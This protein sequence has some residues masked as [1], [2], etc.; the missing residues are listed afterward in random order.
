MSLRAGLKWSLVTVWAL[1]M[2]TCSAG[3]GIEDDMGEENPDGGSGSLCAPGVDTDGDGLNNDVEC[4]LGTNPRK[5][6]TDGDGLWDGIE[7]KYPKV[8]VAKSSPQQRRPPVSCTDSKSCFAGETCSGVSPTKKDS[9]GDGV[10]DG[11]EDLNGDGKID[12]SRGETDPRLFDTDGDGRSD[13]ESGVG[14]CRATGLATVTVTPAPSGSVQLGFDPM[15]GKAEA[16]AG[17]SGASGLLLD[18]LGAGVA[19]AMFSINAPGADV[20]ADATTLETKLVSALGSGTTAVL[21]GRAL[22]THE[23]NP[24]VSS[25]YRVARNTT[26]SAI[27][28]TLVQPF[29]GVMPPG[30]GGAGAGTEFLLDVTTVRRG[31]RDDLIVAVAPRLA[32]ED[33]T[34]PTGIRLSDLVN[35][36]GVA[37]EGK[38]LGFNCQVFKADKPAIADFL[39]T[40]DTSGSMSDDQE[41]LGNTAI[42]FFQRMTSA[43][44]DFRVGVLTSGS[45]SLNL[46]SPGFKFINGSDPMGPLQLCQQVTVGT[47]PMGGGDA[48]QPYP[49]S[50]GSEEPIAAG[51]VAHWTFKSRP[52]PETNPDR[53][54]RD[55]ARVVVF[56]VTDEPESLTNSTTDANDWNNYFSRSQDPEL[57]KPWSSGTY[58]A[59]ALT[60]IVSYFKRNQVLTFGMVPV[61]SSRACGPN[62]HVND[63]PRCTIEGNGGA[64]IPIATALDAEVSAAMNKIVDAVAGATSQFKL[65]RSPI[66]ATIKVRVRGV[67]VPRSRSNGFDYDAAS[68]A[69]VFYGS[70]YRPMMGDEVVVS[71][72]V[73]EGSLG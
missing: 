52:M 33:Y 50:G 19:G 39:W 56:A 1:S 16:V 49:F 28:D 48:L 17:A 47:C 71:Y 58:D 67:D 62:P 44:V 24:A 35:T 11:E 18:D 36:T 45:T 65:D 70:Q 51:V 63:I 27:R 72:R 54:F 20:R 68:K 46:D 73:W 22:T 66:T 26:A 25:T 61:Y 29:V 14:I 6:D 10:N 31:G 40:V 21:T 8:C 13:S 2:A 59:T 7:V 32:L 60:N 34:K 4:M 57:K 37:Q 23:L 43:G 55:G 42:K 3:R 53:K 5:A 15:W 41:R 30:G 12:V 64:T 69:I 38:T 9:D